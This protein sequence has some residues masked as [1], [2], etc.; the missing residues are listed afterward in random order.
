[1]LYLEDEKTQFFSFILWIFTEVISLSWAFICTMGFSDEG[2]PAKRFSK[3]NL[4]NILSRPPVTT[5]F[6]SLS[7]SKHVI[8]LRCVGIVHVTAD[9]AL[10]ITGSDVLSTWRL[11]IWMFELSANITCS[12]SKAVKSLTIGQSETLFVE[13]LKKSYWHKYFVYK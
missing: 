9:L 3:F 7:K 12:P 4:D 13:N 5:I 8:S 6:F 11:V 1:M 2:P 10:S